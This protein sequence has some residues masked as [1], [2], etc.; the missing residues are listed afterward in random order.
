MRIRRMGRR[1]DARAKG[2]TAPLR[3]AVV[4]HPHQVN[5]Y[6]RSLA[7]GHLRDRGHAIH[8]VQGAL[9]F[10]TLSRFDVVHLYRVATREVRGLLRQLRGH[11]VGIVWDN[12]DDLTLG[13]GRRRGG[14]R[15]QEEQISIK[16][17]L[18]IAHVATTPS[19]VL[20]D[21]YQ[22][23]GAQAVRVVDNYLP[24]W[25][26]HPNSAVPGRIRIGWLAAT[27]H[28]ADLKTLRI[29]SML[30]ELL[31]RHPHVDV[32]SIGIG[33]NLSPERYSH[34]PCAV[35]GA[36]GRLARFDIGIALL[37]DTHFNRARSSVKL[38][39]YASCGVPWLA[40]PVGPYIGLAAQQGGH[41][42]A[43]ENWG[44]ALD[45]LIDDADERRRLS[46]AALRWADTERA[47]QTANISRWEEA[48][49]LAHQLAR[50][51]DVL[52]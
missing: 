47:D 17:I 16:E 19:E 50:A 9:A 31:D 14:M 38:K 15:S 51:S 29:R 10:E 30:T 11:G 12:D 45:R 3:V 40:S 4:V 22:S 6:Y 33:V 23:W 20:A 34:T 44:E 13:L 36:P 24:D 5:G 35:R 25:F 41:L 18:R 52:A 2:M 1:D 46:A 37:A 48:V 32:E 26:G 8:M 43:D 42:V 28:R 7:L 49:G 27:E 21:Q 39:E